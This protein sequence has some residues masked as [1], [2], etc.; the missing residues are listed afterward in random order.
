MNKFYERNLQKS[1]IE[2]ESKPLTH[3]LTLCEADHHVDPKWKFK[4][5]AK[6]ECSNITE[7]IKDMGEIEGT[8]WLCDYY[9]DRFGLDVHGQLCQKLRD[10]NTP[11]GFSNSSIFKSFEDDY[12]AQITAWKVQQTPVQRFRRGLF[13]YNATTISNTTVSYNSTS[14]DN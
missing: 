14:S 7:Q 6:P 8:F 3:F 11:L 12:I 4:A 10:S 5:G 9:V 1:L 13:P 2:F